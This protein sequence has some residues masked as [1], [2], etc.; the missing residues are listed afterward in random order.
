MKFSYLSLLQ[1]AI[2]TLEAVIK[3][4]ILTKKA[5]LEMVV[6]VSYRMKET[7]ARVSLSQNKPIGKPIEVRY[8]FFLNCER[9]SATA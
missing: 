4:R 9:C 6:D 2:L 1:D 5:F 3:Y 8:L 7:I